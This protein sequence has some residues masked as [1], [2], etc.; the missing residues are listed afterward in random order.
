MH[1]L[2]LH[3]S[4]Q[5]ITSY[6]ILAECTIYLPCF[7]KFPDCGQPT[8]HTLDEV[9]LIVVLNIVSTS[10]IIHAKASL[11]QNAVK[12]HH[13][14]SLFSFFCGFKSFKMSSEWTCFHFFLL[15]FQIVSNAL[16]R[17]HFASL[18]PPECTI[19]RH[20]YQIFLCSFKVL[21]LPS[22][23]LRFFSE[24]PNR[25]KCRQNERPVVHYCFRCRQGAPFSII[26]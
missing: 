7:Q 25:F 21:L 16:R 3:I 11:F 15:Q 18:L 23:F 9:F 4:L 6:Q 8:S 19:Y 14:P 13:L 2:A 17:H 26:V 10:V 20:Y 22:L 12:I 1:H 24:V 5:V